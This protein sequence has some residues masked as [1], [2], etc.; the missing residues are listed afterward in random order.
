MK[1]LE[2][3]VAVVTGAGRG[4]GRGHALELARHGA[5]VVVND[6]GVAWDG[7]G[8]DQTPAGQVV[9]EIR[10]LGG[11][12]A[13][14]HD[15]VSDWAGAENMIRQA[16]DTF[17]DLHILI[18]NAGIL[19]DRMAFNMT[20]QEWDAVVTVHGKGHF[21]PTHFACTHWRQKSKETGEPVYGRIVHTSSESGLYGNAGQCNYDFAKLG[22]CSFSLCIAREMVRYGVTSNAIAPRARTRMTE[23]TFGEIPA[24]EG[25]DAWHPDNVA[26]W[27]VYLCTPDAAHITGQ[28][29]VV[30]GGEVSLVE[31]PHVVSSLNKDDRWT[32]EELAGKS[33]ELFGDRPTSFADRTPLSSMA[34]GG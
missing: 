10:D 14:N 28:V 18:N 9:A 12:A 15:N 33:A 19:R 20:E 16:I 32:V 11:E 27:V 23:G 24:G 2:G 34:S 6:L 25:F 7:S 30:T 8:E 29:F 13:A 4:V 31:Q 21:A 22:I 1:L 3:K 5:K 26:P 17:G